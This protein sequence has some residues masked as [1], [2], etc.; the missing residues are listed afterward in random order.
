MNSY[1]KGDNVW[2][3]PLL[4]D[5]PKKATYIRSVT[6]DERKSGYREGHI[7][8]LENGKETWVRSDLCDTNY[9]KL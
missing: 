5:E 4:I 1:N 6:E 7:V 8:E 3:R 2:V 9:N